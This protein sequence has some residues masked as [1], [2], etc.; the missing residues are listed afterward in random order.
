MFGDIEPLTHRKQWARD[1]YKSVNPTNGKDH[2]EPGG[3]AA[4]KLRL[5]V[6]KYILNQEGQIPVFSKIMARVFFN[7]ESVFWFTKKHSHLESISAQAFGIQFTE[8]MPLFD[9]FDSGRGKE[10]VDDKIRGSPPRFS[11][12]TW[13]ISDGL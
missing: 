10:R 9:C 7:G 6:I 1:L 4:T 5:E 2:F 12:Y 8:K 13:Q 3:L 11:L